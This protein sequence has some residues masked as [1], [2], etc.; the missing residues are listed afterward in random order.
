MIYV[1]LNSFDKFESFLLSTCS[2]QRIVWG[3]QVGKLYKWSL[4]CFQHFPVRDRLLL[5][6]VKY[7]IKLLVVTESWNLPGFFMLASCLSTILFCLIFSYLS[8]KFFFP[9]FAIYS[10]S[11]LVSSFL[12]FSFIHSWILF[13]PLIFPLLLVF[14]SSV[15]ITTQ[16]L[17]N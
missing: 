8:G 12:V 16:K 7:R 4:K 14:I 15:M 3:F 10:L 13:F 1:H 11:V 2:I 6:H 5:S 9:S 17:K